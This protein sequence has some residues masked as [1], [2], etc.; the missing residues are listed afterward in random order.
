MA[1]HEALS[2]NA[3]PH[4][5][6]THCPT[7][8]K[9]PHG[10]RHWEHNDDASYEALSPN[11]SPHLPITHCP[12]LKKQPHG[13]RHWEHNGNGNH[14]ALGPNASPHLPI[15][16]RPTLKKRGIGRITMMLATKRLAPTPR[17]NPQ[18]ATLFSASDISS[19]K[20][21][22]RCGRSRG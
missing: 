9:Q 10:R 3:S 19:G 16:H 8:K 20:E 5:P 17:P 2:P 22:A 15:T 6:I 14:E 1:N 11:A 13:R 7:L 18:I 12:T 4:P 21:N